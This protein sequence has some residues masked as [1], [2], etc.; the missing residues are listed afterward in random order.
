MDA[1]TYAFW[2]L[3]VCSA[4]AWLSVVLKLTW[5]KSTVGIWFFILSGVMGL[6]AAFI[7]TLQLKIYPRWIEDQARTI[8]YASLAFVLLLLVIN[9]WRKN[10]HRWAWSKEEDKK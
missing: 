8:I 10:W 7:F 2:A 3:A 4:I 9:I 5:W 1:E 6:N